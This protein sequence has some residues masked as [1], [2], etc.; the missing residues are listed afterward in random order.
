LSISFITTGHIRYFDAST[1]YVFNVS[2]S[3]MEGEPPALYWRNSDKEVRPV[4]CIDS[5]EYCSSDGSQCWLLT[6]ETNNPDFELTR[7]ALL[8][9]TIADAI[10]FRMGRALLAQDMVTLYAS[11]QLAPNQWEIEFEQL[12]KTSL[13]R[14]QYNLLDIAVG[15]GKGLRGYDEVE[16]D[17]WGHG[18]LCGKYKYQLP[19]KAGGKNFS[20]VFFVVSVT[21]LGLILIFTAPV[22][23][24]DNKPEEKQFLG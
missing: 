13:A 20:H 16:K 15:A 12:F 10:K 18:R 6:E 4:A 3:Y 22:I 21:F 23:W 7:R 5:Q 14:M 17:T 19:K 9:S 2:T 11:A 1:G 24:L 8:R